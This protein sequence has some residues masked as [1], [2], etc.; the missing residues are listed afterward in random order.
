[1][2]SKQILQYEVII[3]GGGKAGKTLAA[4]L[5]NTGVR[6]ALIEQ[7]PHMIGGA[8][9]NIACIPT[10]SFVQSARVAHTARTAAS[11]GIEVGDLRINWPV[12]RR[13]VEAIT[14]AM[15][16][17]TYKI[18]TSAPALD[19]I[20]ATARFTDAHTVELRDSDGNVRYISGEKIFINTGTRPAEAEIPGLSDVGALDS[21]TIQQI[22]DLPGHLLIIGG[23]Y[24]AIESAQMFRRFGSN[25][26]LIARGA[27]LLPRE[28]SEISEAVTR[29]LA[30]EGIDILLN[31]RLLAA[32][33]TE[34]GL[35]LEIESSGESQRL[36][37]TH[38]LTAIGRSANTEGLNLP[39]A[40]IKTD[41]NGFIQVNDLLETS[42]SRVWALGDCNGGP[43]FTHASLDDFRIVRANVFGQG[44]RSTGDRLMPST[45][46][47]EPELARVGLTENE[48][49]SRGLDI[50]IAKVAMAVAPRAQ[51]SS[52]IEG[53]LKAVV[54][55]RSGRI[56]GCS[57]LAAQAGEMISTIQMAMIAGL[58]Y[59]AL[60]DGV[61]CHP[62]MSEALNYLFAESS[63]LP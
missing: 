8:C 50:R 56:L 61:L 31:A 11:F 30:A 14:G 13:R 43:E 40:G 25:V 2:N 21:R 22:E 5:G 20:I 6:T 57:L 62:T 7:D 17:A 46:F 47:I 24:V 18:L 54:E 15:R 37:G 45:V 29:V 49:R 26:T 48:A 33:K 1:M 10:K 53:M 44:G 59:T 36:T 51:T 58:P 35:T 39:A 55:T 34:K 23:G 60:R 19:L 28:D 63:F 4:F 41:Q 27:R 16:Q 32:D 38:L 42:A 12:I 52:Q 3:V 9:I